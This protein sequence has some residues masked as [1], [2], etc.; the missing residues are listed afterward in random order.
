[1]IACRDG[2]KT[3]RARRTIAL[4]SATMDAL[5]AWRSAR[6]AKAKALGAMPDDDAYVFALELS[7]FRWPAEAVTRRVARVAA[8]TGVSASV[9][10]LRRYSMGRLA[11]LGVGL[12]VI[13]HRL[14]LS[15]GAGML[16]LFTSAGSLAPADREA[17]RL[18][19]HDLDQALA[20]LA[21]VGFGNGQNG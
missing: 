4:D 1:M 3:A 17:A 13:S 19:G 18:L 12:D 5:A 21:P 8:Q 6:G 10:D 20:A 2:G 15:A 14:G 9:A 11:A 16:P 7:G